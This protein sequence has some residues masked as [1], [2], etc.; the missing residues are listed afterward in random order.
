[1]YNTFIQV[2]LKQLENSREILEHKLDDLHMQEINVRS[3]IHRM[4]LR[5]S[6]RQA[7]Y[8]EKRKI[9]FEVEKWALK[10]FSS[11]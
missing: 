9:R 7:S 10:E 1:M 8:E 11:N 6:V 4:F 5:L 2:N 3:W